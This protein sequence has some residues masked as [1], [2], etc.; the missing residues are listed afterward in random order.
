M[1][2]TPIED[3]HISKKDIR[4]ILL[5]CILTIVQ[6]FSIDMYIPSL[7]WI[8][9][10]LHT[11]QTIVQ[12]TI[13]FYV[14]GSAL[15]VLFS[16]PLSDKIG[17]KPVILYGLMIMIA[18]S[19][20]CLFSM[21]GPMLLIG[22][23][24]QGIGAGF[25][26]SANRAVVTDSF[27]AKKLVIIGSYFGMLIAVSPIF[28]PVI[29]GYLEH[30]F[31]WRAN[32]VV[33]AFFYALTLV[34]FALFFQ[35][36]NHTQHPDKI[37]LSFITKRYLYLIRQPNFR[38]F[39]LCGGLT[40][41]ISVAYATVAPYIFESSLHMTPIAFGWLG[42]FIGLSNI[43]GR[44]TMPPLVKKFSMSTL[45][46]IGMFIVLCAG[47]FFLIALYFGWLS[48]PLALIVVIAALLGQ[49]YVASMAFS[50]GITPFRHI[51]GA[52]NSLLSFW[53]V[54]LSFLISSALSLSSTGMP[55]SNALAWMYIF[56][57]AVCL[58]LYFQY[59]SARNKQST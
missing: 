56:I 59:Q 14:L 42:I 22:R 53:Q 7:P 30:Y 37:S 18:G 4:I 47:I 39:A 54:G 15:S 6:F 38:I 23:V 50:M 44:L 43:V 20:I 48:I 58:I 8:K 34:A 19:F 55:E 13:G 32:F 27:S 52:A 57:G 5:S 28:A 3:L 24:I 31:S 40:L 9:D 2:E 45:L 10:S 46:V 21:N 41:G 16:G 36:T 1:T 12:L 17:R 49:T 25:S 35:E 33:L 11:T 51:G 26:M 29:G